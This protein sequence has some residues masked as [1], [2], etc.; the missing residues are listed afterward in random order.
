MK[1]MQSVQISWIK[2]ISLYSIWHATCKRLKKC[3]KIFLMNAGE[4]IHDFSCWSA[5]KLYK[6]FPAEPVSPHRVTRPP[7]RRHRFLRT[8]F[9][10]TIFIYVG[11]R[12]ISWKVV[13]LHSA[14]ATEKEYLPKEYSSQGARATA[15]SNE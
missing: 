14:Y 15:E 5:K 1:Y 12:L 2:Q 11:N 9:M 4:F 10:P 7:R 3:R 13:A 6:F 8:S